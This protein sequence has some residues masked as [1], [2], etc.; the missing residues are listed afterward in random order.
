MEQTQ[1]KQFTFYDLYWDLIRQSDDASTGR[2]A[3]N[4]CK[5]MFNNVMSEFKDKSMQGYFNLCKR[6]MD[7]SK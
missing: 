6:K 7:L 5:Y 4:I 3:M 1:L 2:M